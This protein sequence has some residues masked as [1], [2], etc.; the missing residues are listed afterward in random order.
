MQATNGA[1][2]LSGTIK[3]TLNKGMWVKNLSF[4]RHPSSFELGKVMGDWL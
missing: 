2:P 4:N 3:V 1:Q